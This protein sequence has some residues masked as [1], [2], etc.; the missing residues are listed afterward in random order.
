MIHELKRYEANLHKADALRARFLTVTLP[1]FSRL[2]ITVRHYWTHPSE[3]DAMYYLAEFPDEAS[4][5]AAWAAFGADAQWKAAKAASEKEGPLL[6]S[7][8][9]VLLHP[10]P[11]S[12]P[13][14]R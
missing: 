4:R 10:Q 12:M 1:I 8:T 5:T 3:P 6:A 9:T 14:M 2:G 11:L 13:E 7:Q